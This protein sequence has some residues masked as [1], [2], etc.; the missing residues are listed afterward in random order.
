MYY[1]DGET[2]FYDIHPKDLIC[3]VLGYNCGPARTDVLEPNFYVV[4]PSIKD[5]G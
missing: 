5:S 4:K 3:R 2:E 1:L